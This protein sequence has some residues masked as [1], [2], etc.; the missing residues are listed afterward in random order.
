[1]AIRRLSLVLMLTTVVA[2]MLLAGMGFHKGPRDSDG[3]GVPDGSDN[4]IFTFNPDQIDS[5]GDGSGDACNGTINVHADIKP[6]SDPNSI[7]C[8]KT[9]GVIPVGVLS[10]PRWSATTIDAD[11]VRFGPSGA[12][13]VHTDPNTGA[14]LRHVE[15]LDGN[16]LPDMVFHFK[17][18][19]TGIRCGDT[20]ATIRGIARD[21]RGAKPFIG[22]DA[23]R[24]VPPL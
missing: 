6:G 18:G 5:D 9:N 2:L 16:G 13:E 4:C 14:A 10:R 17:S 7:N 15:D 12:K 1:M 8:E 24:T 23:I 21:S 19:D 11:S 20:S 22:G 3:D